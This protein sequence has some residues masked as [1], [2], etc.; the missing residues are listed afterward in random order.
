M[1][2]NCSSCVL[3]SG[4]VSQEPVLFDTTIKENIM[5]GREG[6]TMDEVIQATKESNA[7]DFIQKLPKVR[8]RRDNTL[9]HNSQSPV[10][11]NAVHSF[12]VSTLFPK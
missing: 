5:F 4:V 1:S 9:Y 3:F 11:V 6:V 2:V 7:Y 10:C 8:L 12:E